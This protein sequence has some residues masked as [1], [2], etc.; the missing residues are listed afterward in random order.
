MRIENRTLKRQRLSHLKKAQRAPG[1]DI[2]RI[3]TERKGIG[4]LKGMIILLIALLQLGLLAYLH[5]MVAAAFRWY[6]IAS[7]VLDVITCFYILG[8]SKNG[9]SKAVW[10]MIVL[11][12]FPV[13]FLIYFMS[14]E[15]IF[16]RSSRKRSASILSSS[17]GEKRFALVSGIVAGIIE[18][19]AFRPKMEACPLAC[20]IESFFILLTSWGNLSIL[21]AL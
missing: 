6:L 7:V 19:V 4:K 13:G 17:A 8:S 18:K 9:R 21:T 11:V 20:L 1:G 12:L 10:I 2:V 5:I 15:N 16:F 3:K 14:D